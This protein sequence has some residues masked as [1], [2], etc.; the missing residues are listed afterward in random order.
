MALEL[1]HEQRTGVITLIK[2]HIAEH[3]NCRIGWAMREVAGE[4]FEK[5][6][7]L[8][9]K[10]ANTIIQSGEYIKE[11]SAQ[12]DKDW[13]ILVNPQ[14]KLVQ[15]NKWTVIINIILCI[16]TATA[17]IIAICKAFLH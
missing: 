7:H 17:A 15:F 4:K 10:I 14:Y 16:I 6:I 11:E 1:T 9:E 5:S 12:A 8:K 13:N 3:G 2:D